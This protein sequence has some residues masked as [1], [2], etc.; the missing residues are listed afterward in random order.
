MRFDFQHDNL[1]YLDRVEVGGARREA[2]LSP[3]G[4]D[5]TV[6]RGFFRRSYK[7]AVHKT[8]TNAV[9]FKRIEQLQLRPQHF[10]DYLTTQVAS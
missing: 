8:T 1:S 4:N 6:C 3:D 9:P 2:R 10:V 7:R 5:A